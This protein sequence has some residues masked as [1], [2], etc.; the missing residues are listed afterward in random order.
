MIAVSGNCLRGDYDKY[1]AR[2][3]RQLCQSF[4]PQQK[5]ALR[6]QIVMRANLCGVANPGA[7]RVALACLKN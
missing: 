5:Q 6:E 3:V 2:Q 7:Y 1:Q 4:T